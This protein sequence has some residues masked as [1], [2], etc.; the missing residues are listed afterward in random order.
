M[1]AAAPPPAGGEGGGGPLGGGG[2]GGVGREPGCPR[3]LR[4]RGPGQ[5]FFTLL[6]LSLFICWGGLSSSGVISLKR[7]RTN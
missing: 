6:F 3:G 5:V 2:G 7:A 1:P 4:L